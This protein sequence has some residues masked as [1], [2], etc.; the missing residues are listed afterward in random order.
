MRCPSCGTDNEADSR[1]C[2]GCGARLPGPEAPRVAPTIKLSD[3]APY[4][5]PAPPPAHSF[6]T[7]DALVPTLPRHQSL[8]PTGSSRPPASIPPTGSRAPASIP[9]TASRAPVSIPPTNSRPPVISS[10]SLSMPLP[11]RR[12]WGLIVVVVV[13]DLAL[14]GAGGLLLAKGLSAK[15][16]ATSLVTPAPAPAPSVT[17]IPSPSAS[18]S[19]SPSPPPGASPPPAAAPAPP[20]PPAA[21]KHDPKAAA[22]R[23]ADHKPTT[24]TP[25]GG[26]GPEDPYGADLGNEIEL[27]AS[28]SKV[29]FD[30]CY[31]DASA[32]APV[33]GEV[34]IAFQVVADGRVTHAQAVDNTTGSTALGTC[35]AA[36]I[37][38][39]TFAVHP[40]Q[41]TDFMRPFSYP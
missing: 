24:R 31:Q 4:P 19:P 34:H 30:R 9:P 23:H 41:A 3:D 11:P 36:T 37:A 7:D 28:R 12:P 8:P 38:R 22:K 10:P 18:P 40:A 6:G 39:W 35:L 17:P 2:G 16:V 15:S 27:A 13:I 26:E 33:H 29:A 20:P 25:P 14:A 5:T 32:A 21:E 1:F